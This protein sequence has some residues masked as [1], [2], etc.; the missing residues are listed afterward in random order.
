MN[1]VDPAAPLPS[2]LRTLLTLRTL[3]PLAR[4]RLVTTLGTCTVLCYPGLTICSFQILNWCRYTSAR[5]GGSG[6]GGGGSLLSPSDRFRSSALSSGQRRAFTV[7]GC[8]SLIQMTHS[9]NHPVSTTLVHFCSFLCRDILV[10][11]LCFQI[12]CVPLHHGPDARAPPRE[13][14]AR[15]LARES[16][17]EAA[18]R[19]PGGEDRV[20]GVHDAYVHGGGPGAC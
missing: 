15:S 16:H 14:R 9:L 4:K 13:E 10:S 17:A 11:S 7:W 18:L 19:R 20:A 5:S 8:T 1:P 12:Q 2:L 6:G 3:P